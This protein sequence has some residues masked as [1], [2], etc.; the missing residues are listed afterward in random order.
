M[1]SMRAVW[2]GCAKNRVLEIFLVNAD[3]RLG[4]RKRVTR[5]CADRHTDRK[6]RVR[7]TDPNEQQPNKKR[8]FASWLDIIVPPFPNV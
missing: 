7:T 6:R 4:T 5:T 3:V 1:S 8:R 2:A